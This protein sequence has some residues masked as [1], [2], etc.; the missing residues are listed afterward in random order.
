M[1]FCVCFVLLY[2][3]NV[4]SDFTEKVFTSSYCLVAL[5]LQPKQIVYCNNVVKP[6]TTL[7]RRNY[8]T[9]VVES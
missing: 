1:L 2:N 5:E 6:V 9:D 7:L 3:T 8:N 4:D